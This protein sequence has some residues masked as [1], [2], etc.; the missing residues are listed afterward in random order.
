VAANR[1]FAE[2]AGYEP[3]DLVD[4]R[5][6]DLLDPAG[7]AAQTWA[8]HWAQTV[9]RTSPAGTVAEL[10]M[11]RTDG[12]RLD[13]H[14]VSR[15]HFDQAGG[16]F[17]CRTA[18]SDITERRRTEKRLQESEVLWRAIFDRAANPILVIDAN[19]RIA[20]LNA[21]TERFM[22][23]GRTGMM[24]RSLVEFFPAALG[25]A[26]HD[27]LS[28]LQ[29]ERV[30]MELQC[31]TVAGRKTLE[32]T[33]TPVTRDSE[34]MLVALGTD[35]TGRK[36]AESHLRHKVLH[37]H[38]TNLPNRLL[39]MEDL[40]RAV[41]R[42]HRNPSRTFALL[43]LDVDGFKQINDRL[44]HLLGDQLLMQV[45][46]RLMR[47]VREVDTVARFGGDEFA[48]LVDD[49]SGV[50]DATASAERILNDMQTPFRLGDTDVKTGVSIGIALFGRDGENAETLLSKAD[51]AMYRAKANG[52]GRYAC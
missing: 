21:A 23:M 42:C 30:P 29:A 7:E 32:L 9:A 22:G 37:D 49:V 17:E 13:V 50:E 15:A 26:G 46:A 11:C 14:V 47:C 34:G 52:R 28:L 43:F 27:V 4:R 33:V 19:G 1:T 31:D 2:M 38:L 18:V 41:R 25:P 10:R 35:V 16:L 51:A 40:D 20:D 44:G 45:G 5:L 39:L 8:V 6:T 3:A 24:G 48:V 12:T 36:A